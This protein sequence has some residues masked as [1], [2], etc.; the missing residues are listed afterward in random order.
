MQRRTT[1]THRGFTLI[2]LVLVLVIVCTALAMA[3]PSMGGWSR[4]QKLRDAG[5]QFLAVARY[6]RLNA[7]ANSQVYR[8]YVDRAAGT[9]WVVAQE[10]Q[11]FVPLAN[12]F[13]KVFSVPEGFR[14]ALTDPSRQPLEFVEF[15][16]T[17]RT[18]P[19]SVTIL[20]SDGEPFD[21]ICPTPAEGFM[22]AT[23]DPQG[24]AR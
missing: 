5:E 16:P 14:I 21:L 24:V 2:E 20:A 22:V 10:G 23:A 4:G 17:G 19:A 15:S 8:L 6:A 1:T 13:G 12:D 9:Y 18:Q 3:A 11:E 7:G